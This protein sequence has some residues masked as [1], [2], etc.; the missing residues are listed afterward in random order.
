MKDIDY[1]PKNI[2][3][4]E[5]ENNQKL[6]LCG[7]RGSI[8][9]GTYIPDTAPDSVDDIDIMGV[10]LAPPKFYIGLGRGRR[11]QKAI[12]HL[13]GKYDVVYYELRKFANM[14]LNSNPNVLSLLWLDEPHYLRI[15]EQG[16]LLIDVRDAFLSKRR[17]YKAFTGY[18]YGQ[19]KKMTHFNKQ[20][21]MG[22]K[23][24]K[25]VERF[26]YDVKNACHLIR[27]LRMGI[28]ILE[29]GKINVFREDADELK[30]IKTG[31]WTLEEVKKES[32]ILFEA[33][34]DAF[35]NSVLPDEPD[36][37]KVENVVIKILLDYVKGGCV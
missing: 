20:G 32:T 27:L 21:Y 19:S 11:Y 31:K 9:H 34:K 35:A 26:G 22:A 7:Y 25:L 13:H 18:A 36:I 4:P 15:T 3:S 12:E 5:W 28:E 23:R 10:Y 2:Y 6:I 30:D 24:K 17:I 8:S 14:F 1:M 33:A 37:E 16:Q 29:T